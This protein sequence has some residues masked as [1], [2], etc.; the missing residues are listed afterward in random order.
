MQLIIAGSREFNN[1]NALEKY[2]DAFVKGE[3]E[4]TILS[5]TADGADKLGEEW[6]ESMG[7]PVRYFKP[8]W[9][10]GLAGGPMRNKVMVAEA[11]HA[12]FFW[13]GKSNGTKDCITRCIAKGIPY[14][15]IRF[16]SHQVCMS[17]EDI[18]RIFNDLLGEE[19]NKLVLEILNKL[20]W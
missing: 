10:K 18:E 13:N 5:G 11:T 7:Y 9:S 1:A 4:V 8:D 19:A 16:T 2:C 20:D 12:I 14:K 6:A 3:K 17:E 15:V